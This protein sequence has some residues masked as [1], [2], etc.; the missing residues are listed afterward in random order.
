VTRASKCPGCP[1]TDSPPGFK[2]TLADKGPSPS[3]GAKPR[4][5]LDSQSTPTQTV[6]DG[7]R[8]EH[9]GT[10][11]PPLEIF[12]P[13]FVDFR[14]RCHSAKPTREDLIEVQ[15]FMR[16]ASLIYSEPEY[17]AELRYALAKFLRCL[18]SN[19]DTS[20]ADGVY[21]FDLGLFRLSIFLIEFKTE[22][23]EGDSDASTQAGLSMKRLWSE[24]VMV[25]VFCMEYKSHL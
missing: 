1:S 10:S 25:R 23:G 15:E 11:A 18:E 21:S 6:F 20:A 13:V 8:V 17:A 9:M 4:N 14:A 22:W 16:S 24:D 7:R 2:A 19:T 5:Y 12:H 3:I